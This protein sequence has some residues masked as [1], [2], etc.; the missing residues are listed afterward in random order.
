[1]PKDYVPALSDEQVRLMLE[2]DL[3][4]NNG[5]ICTCG[6]CELRNTCEFSYDLY[7]KDGD[8]LADK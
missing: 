8:C 3:Y 2:F 7:N 5:A 6:E 1:M 4:Y